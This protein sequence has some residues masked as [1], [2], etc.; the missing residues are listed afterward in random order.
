M[1]RL[2]TL[3][4]VAVSMIAFA[5]AANAAVGTVVPILGNAVG[6]VVGGA[7]GLIGGLVG[8]KVGAAVGDAVSPLQSVLSTAAVESLNSL[9]ILQTNWDDEIL[10]RENLVS[11][12]KDTTD[13]EVQKRML[14]DAGIDSNLVKMAETDEALDK[15]AESA[16]NAAQD[17]SELANAAAGFLMSVNNKYCPILV[18]GG[19]YY[20][21][22]YLCIICAV[23]FS[24][25]CS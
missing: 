25:I 18:K 6:A 5:V 7:I 9:T 8:A 4:L 21:K 12:M 24:G 16:L 11:A 13:I 14:L 17:N 20:F 3:T 1:K 15:L 23:V 2:I 22:I 19:A 10:E